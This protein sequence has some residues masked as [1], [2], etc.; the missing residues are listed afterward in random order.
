MKPDTSDHVDDPLLN[1]KPTS[2]FKAGGLLFI[3]PIPII[4]GSN[5]KIT[6][7]LVVVAIITL[8]LLYD[9]LL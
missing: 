2:S 9:F 1:R 5:W 3:G 7:I 8:V 6:L 4:F